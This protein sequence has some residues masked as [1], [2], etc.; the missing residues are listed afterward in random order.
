M[1][2]DA[3]RMFLF[4]DLVPGLVTIACLVAAWLL[5][6]QNR[7]AD[8]R[9]SFFTAATALY[10]LYEDPWAMQG[11]LVAVLTADRDTREAS[12]A[13]LH[14]AAVNPSRL[15]DPLRAADVEGTSGLHG[16]SRLVAEGIVSRRAQRLHRAI[17]R[18][19]GH[20]T[21]LRED[22][23]HRAPRFERALRTGVRVDAPPFSRL[24]AGAL[25]LLATVLVPDEPRHT[26]EVAL[27][28]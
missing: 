4:F 7:Q 21:G 28:A 11:V 22:L 1:D 23:A 6:R 25:P 10:L 8:H 19:D 26:G 17:E 3:L 16:P 12:L 14:A 20:L 2:S 15:I 9:T 24:A 18:Y 27:P 13:A 5:L